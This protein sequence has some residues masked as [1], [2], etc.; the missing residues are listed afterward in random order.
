VSGLAWVRRDVGANVVASVLDVSRKW[1]WVVFPIAFLVVL[2]GENTY[3]QYIAGFIMIYG[4]SALGLDWLMGRAGV[5]SLGNGAIMA[6]GAFTAALLGQQGWNFL[7]ILVLVT[8]LGG[9]LGALLSLPALR[10]HGVY[11][12]LVTL[13]LQVVV[14][15]AARRFQATST[16]YVAGIPV[17]APTI[18]SFELELGRSWM[19]VLGL[20]LGAATLLLRNMYG[21]QPGRAWMAV[22]ESELAARTIGVPARKAKLAAFVGSTAL[23]SLSGGLLAFYT[24]RVAADGFTLTFAISFVVMVILGGLRSMPGVLF[25]TALVT[26]APLMLGQYAQTLPPLAGGLTG[27]F[28]TNVF[29]INSGLFGL[30]VMVGLLYM[31]RGVVPT[32]STAVGGFATRLRSRSSRRA[33]GTQETGEQPAFARTPLHAVPEGDNGSAPARGESDFLRLEDVR[34]SYRNGAQALAGIDLSLARGEIVGIVGRNGVGKS[35]LMR[36]VTG[37]YR[38][39][40]VRVSGRIEL[41]GNNLRGRSPIGT[42]RQGVALVPER[43]KVFPE[44]TV[45]E[46]LRHIGDLEAARSAMP[47]AFEMFDRKWTS[48]AGLL[49]GGE[50]QLLALAVAASLGPQVL[51][52]DEMSLGL[53]PIAIDNVVTSILDLQANT[54][55][56]ILVVEQNVQVARA[57]CRRVLLMEAGRIIST[58][59]SVL[60]ETTAGTILPDLTMEGSDAARR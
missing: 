36:A 44:L 38:S 32:V 12:A 11:F 23:I 52:V 34:L 14:V 33:A 60:E 24:G 6:F 51:L 30:L 41:D 17:D 57:M 1:G 16:D 35:S 8:V 2:F 39:E 56:T 9:L 15:F 10:L 49:S 40:G 54:G 21:S 53:S 43:E 18:G 46:H 3:H 29:F 48:R 50:R 45:Q 47:N 27:W 26:I 42:A 59:D 25:G 20:L 4:L 31:P 37:F 13:A 55:V 58:W 7:P 19:L 5:V 22:R 28:R